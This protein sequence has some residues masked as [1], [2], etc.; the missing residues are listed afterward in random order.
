MKAQL[1]NHNGTP[2]IFLD[3]QPAFFGC[4]LVGYM[5]A[6]KLTEH[7]PIARKYAEAGVH[8]YSIDTLTH[9][10]VGPRPDNPSPYDFSLVLPR[11]QSYIDVD[12]DALFLLRMGF[13]TRWLQGNWWN[14][15]YPDE[16]EVLSDGA[17]WG[18]SFAS[19]VW[20][21][22]VN[23]LI[24]AFIDH[25][26]D[27]GLYDR[28]LAFQ[29]GAGSSGEWIKDMS[30]MVLPT[31]DYSVPMRGHFRAWLRERYQADTAALQAAWADATVTFDSAEVP[32]AA[33]QWN[34]TTGHSFRDPRLEQKTVDFYDCF[35]E[36]CADDLIEFCH[37]IREVTG[38]EK[39]TGG[40]FG[41]VMELAWN[42]CFFAG[43]STLEQSAVSTIQRS[44]HLGLHKVLHSPHIDFLV[45]PYGYAFRGLGGDGLPMQPG[46][47]LRAH[48]KI[49]LMEEDTLMHNNFDPGGRNQSVENSIAVYQ[50]NF[51]QAITHAHAVT[52]FEVASLCEHPSLVDERNHWIKR[53]QEL[54]TWALRLDRQPAAEVAVFLDDESYYYES[55]R[56]DVDIPLIWRQRVVNLNRFGAPHDVYL[57]DDLLAG[58]LPAYKLYIFLNPFHLDNRRR[59]ALK[60]MLRRDGRVALWLYA[61]GYLNSDALKGQAAPLHTDHMTDLM[62]FRFG[63]GDSPW[64]P[65]MHVTNFKHPITQ[66]LPQDWFWGSTNP[67]GPLFHLEDPEATTLGEVVYSLGRCKPGFGVK[68]FN[69]GALE[70]SWRSVYIASPD[71]PAP[72]LRGIARFAEVHLYNE[73][74]DVLY[75]T[76]DLLSVHSVAGGLRTFKLPRRVE[77]VYDLFDGRVLARDAAE[78]KV[79]LPPASTAL[80]FTGKAADLAGL[81]GV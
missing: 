72:V 27:V 52:W 16:V 74:G 48:G 46:E 15:T 39:L 9:E 38:G 34:T 45:S 35:A 70:T 10:W 36:L 18:Q 33:E 80:Y 25:L 24:R 47:S 68:V 76:P 5:D 73:D 17:R 19:T 57:L 50:R 51:A 41:Y 81:S 14:E 64:G 53:F 66:G 6:N 8:I 61:A 31:M 67:I 44:G 3:D 26:R 65:L 21:A 55:I 32:S 59:E 7:Q 56:N 78:F 71:V 43:P 1:K 22:Q 40:F 4:H 12:P 37:T 23:D 69:T 63:Q 20:R 13:E 75:A 49:Y 79:E 42:M 2:T 62:G 29:V 28:V 11:M 60:R 30:C 58:N 54:G 77:L